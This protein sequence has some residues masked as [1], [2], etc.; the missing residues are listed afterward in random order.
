MFTSI[1]TT[2][3]SSTTSTVKMQDS[4]KEIL[5]K[6]AE[7][8]HKME[9]FDP[10]Q[11][12]INEDNLREF[13]KIR[14]KIEEDYQA[15]QNKI[16]LLPKEHSAELGE[17]RGAS[18][19]KE[20]FKTKMNHAYYRSKFR[21]KSYEV[22]NGQIFSRSELQT[23]REG[24]ETVFWE[25]YKKVQL[26]LGFGKVPMEESV[27]DK[28]LSGDKKYEALV[29]GDPEN[30]TSKEYDGCKVFVEEP[31]ETKVEHQVQE[32]PSE[33]LRK[34]ELRKKS[35]VIEKSFDNITYKEAFDGDVGVDK[36][37]EA[38][39]VLKND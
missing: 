22:M 10:Y 21:Q 17:M 34:S 5:V 24:S 8:Y 29:I 35:D 31:L 33:H 7:L 25:L 12:Q 36:E 11:F 9:V 15:V 13:E 27:N 4:E 28:L 14:D 23:F 39:E 32:M 3:Y 30:N 26:E 19:K 20:R 2:S 38:K 1:Q 37:T 6:Q 16:N 18:W